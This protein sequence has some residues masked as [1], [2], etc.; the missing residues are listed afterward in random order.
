MING[1]TNQG[2]IELGN[3]AVL[4]EGTPSGTATFTNVG[5]IDLNTV[6]SAFFVQGNVSLQGHGHLELGGGYI[7]S[8]SPASG[9]GSPAT[10]SNASNIIGMGTIGDGVTSL[11]LINQSTGVIDATGA[12][13]LTIN[14]IPGGT[15]DVNSGILESTNPNNLASVGGLILGQNLTVDNQNGV[16]EAHGTN[17][18]VILDRVMLRR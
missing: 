8:D 5:A 16:I 14:A 12:D 2:T 18:H 9:V 6:S 10:L 7:T 3:L 15:V 4:S 1:G 17:T 11:T 13:A